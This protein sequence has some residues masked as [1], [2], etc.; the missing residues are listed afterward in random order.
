MNMDDQM[1]PSD[2]EI[3]ERPAMIVAAH[4]DDE[5]IGLGTRLPYFANLQAIVHITD[6][7]PR[8][9][10]DVANAGVASWQEYA[11]LRRNEFKAALEEANCN[12]QQTP[13]FWCPDQRALYRIAS[14]ARRLASL[15]ER[16]RPQH[17]FTHPYEGG[18]PDHDAVAA[19]VHCA[20]ALLRRRGVAC[21]LILEFASYHSSGGNLESECFLACNG[22]SVR[23]RVLTH[24]Q[25]AAKQK[26]F[27][28]YASQQRT[29]AW[30]PLT[31]EP[32]RLAP[33][34]DFNCPPHHGPLLYESFGWGLT[35]TK[36]CRVAAA[37]LRKFV[38]V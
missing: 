5:T 33:A 34:Y 11:D 38:T 14:H 28:C 30:F 9:G 35:G 16:C 7:A 20:S 29:L 37:G 24:E 17:V 2:E 10:P 25:Q 8:S 21:P 32:I 6:G 15:F 26:M 31:R 36:W 19:A 4:P 3:A 18:H 27:A 13:C 12:P 1:C 23:D 22:L